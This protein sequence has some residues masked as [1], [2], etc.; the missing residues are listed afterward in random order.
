MVIMIEEYGS[1]EVTGRTSGPGEIIF[2]MMGLF[3]GV[4]LW[5]ENSL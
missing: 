2:E 3:D 5:L 4:F 1:R